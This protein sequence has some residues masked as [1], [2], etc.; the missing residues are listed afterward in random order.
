MDAINI[1]NSGL[2]LDPEYNRLNE[3]WGCYQTPNNDEFYLFDKPHGVVYTFIAN[4]D[5]ADKKYSYT[6]LLPNN[7]TIKLG[8][9]KEGVEQIDLFLKALL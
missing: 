6:V 3:R 7:N 5:R 2:M 4:Y 9:D 1:L 8:T